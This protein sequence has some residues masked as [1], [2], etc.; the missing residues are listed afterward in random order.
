MKCTTSCASAASNM[1]SANGK[2]SAGASWTSTSGWRSRAAATNDS[3]GSTA[4]TFDA[5]TRSTSSVVS[6]PGP[7]P[8]SSTRWPGPTP[9]RSANCGVRRTEYLPMKRSYESAA[10]AKLTVTLCH[11]WPWTIALRSRAG[12]RGRHDLRELVLEVDA[13]HASDLGSR[14]HLAIRG[15]HVERMGRVEDEPHVVAKVGADASGR[16]AAKVRLNP[17]HRD[18]ADL[19]LAQPCVEIDISVKRRVHRLDNAQI[20][21]AGGGFFQLVAGCAALERSTL[22][23]VLNDHDGV[24]AP[25]PRGNQLGDVLLGMGIVAWSERWIIE[26]ALNVDH[27]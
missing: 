9:A 26:A 6:A 7:Q 4:A 20:G 14:H 23:I 27:Q 25:A 13:G 15:G 17:A 19:A 10:T 16:L 11:A 12:C 1:P 22:P 21:V 5:P 18:R 24:A 3:D 2:V 8:T